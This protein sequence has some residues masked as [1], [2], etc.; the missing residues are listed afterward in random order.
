MGMFSNPAAIWSASLY[1]LGTPLGTPIASMY[2]G[3]FCVGSNGLEA[4][5]VLKTC[6]RLRLVM[7][8]AI[9]NVGRITLFPTKTNGAASRTKAQ[10]PVTFFSLSCTCNLFPPQ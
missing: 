9:S 10:T 3:E 4:E 1:L 2:V 5:R 7:D 6:R 8:W